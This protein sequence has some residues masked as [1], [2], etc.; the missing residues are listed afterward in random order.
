MIPSFLGLSF[1]KVGSQKVYAIHESNLSILRLLIPYSFICILHDSFICNIC[2]K[3]PMRPPIIYARCCKRLIGCQ[4]CIDEWYVGSEQ[5]T[6]CPV[7]WSERGYADT[8][9]LKGIDEFLQAIVSLCGDKD[10]SN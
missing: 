8:T 3:S 9:L 5:S 7:C 1:W 4:S 10:E 6:T 2:R